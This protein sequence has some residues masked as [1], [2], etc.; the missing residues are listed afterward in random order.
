M[1]EK[2]WRRAESSRGINYSLL[3]PLLCHA[4]SIQLLTVLL[5]VTTA[6]RILE[7][8]LPL[9]WL[10]A[11]SGTFA[12]LP[13]FLAVWVGRFI[14]RGNDA[15]VAWMG[16][17]LMFAPTICFYLWP[18]NQ[19]HLLAYTAILGVGHLFIMASHQMLTVRAGGEHG[20]DSAFGN[21]SVAQAIGQG[22][23]PMVVGFVGGSA[24]LPPT[25]ELFGYA[26][27]GIA[28]N[29]MIGFAIRPI[30]ISS[31]QSKEI[32]TIPVLELLKTP[33]LVTILMASILTITASDLLS[34]YLPLLGTERY[35][36][37]AY[38]GTILSVRSAASILSRFGFASM[39]RIVGR[40]RLTV[41]TM[42][43]AGL[44]FIGLALP[45]PLYGLYVASAIMGVGLGISSTLS[46]SSIAEIVPPASRGTAMTIRIT[47][48]RLG[49]VL[50]PI[51]A[52][53]IAASAGAAGVLAIIGV[54]LIGSAIAVQRTNKGD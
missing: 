1:L 4:F 20:R 30:P 10:G 38:I 32:S 35:I 18:G 16:S 13:V 53:L 33:G 27:I 52:S 7:L 21:F 43:C 50:V 54:N 8:D 26:A 22:V 48:N 9:V 15:K 46:V 29:F 49:Q 12:L 39:I 44:G 2:L 24:H 40:R 19:Y 37:V 25:H 3:L 34:T 14:D 5:R 41:L 42:I 17:A 23:G 6:Y 51:L 31:R 36:G 47:G 28:L 11:I 45:I